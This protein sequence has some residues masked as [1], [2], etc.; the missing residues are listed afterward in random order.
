MGKKSKRKRQG[1]ARNQSFT[2]NEDDK[3]QTNLAYGI[4]IA[5]ILLFIWGVKLAED[6]FIPNRI[7]W[8]TALAG[9]SIAVTI[10][11]WLWRRF[12]H[13]WGLSWYISLTLFL[14][15]M[16]GVPVPF[17]AVNAIN[18]YFKSEDEKQVIPT[19]LKKE[20]VNKR[21][22][23]CRYPYVVVSLNDIPTRINFPCG[24][25]ILDEYKVAL[26]VSEGALGY[27]VITDKRLI[28]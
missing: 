17:F 10:I 8:L 21:K 16:A 24:T 1:P 3:Y 6:T 19:L 5:G 15:I 9:A 7:L 11:A 22:R 23:K 18:Y 12:R 28:E 26:T 14:G 13:E 25:E 4:L 2:S 27:Y 20:Y